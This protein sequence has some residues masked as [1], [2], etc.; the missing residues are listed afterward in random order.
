MPEQFQFVRF[1]DIVA[2]LIALQVTLLDG[3][4]RVS[5]GIGGATTD[6]QSPTA[7]RQQHEILRESQEI[8]V[9]LR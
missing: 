9:E 6:V 3:Q 5:C 2:K 1:V 7:C 4:E 8:V